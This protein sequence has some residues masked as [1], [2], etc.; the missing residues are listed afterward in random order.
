M[1]PEAYD[2]EI[3]SPQGLELISEFFK[4]LSAFEVVKA[5][6]TFRRMML[7]NDKLEE[8]STRKSE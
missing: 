8:E 7:V 5:D 4:E 3:S 1:D 6:P 2:V